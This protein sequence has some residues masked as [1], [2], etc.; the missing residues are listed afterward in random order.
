MCVSLSSVA[1]KGKVHSG[2]LELNKICISICCVLHLV[3]N[4]SWVIPAVLNVYWMWL[5]QGK[6]AYLPCRHPPP[7]PPPQGTEEQALLTSDKTQISSHT[8]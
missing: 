8:V 6:H 4:K 7:P 1:F 2:L 5:I 3:V